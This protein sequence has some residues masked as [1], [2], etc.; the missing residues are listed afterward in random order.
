VIEAKV[1]ISDRAV[2]YPGAYIARGSSIGERTII[3]SNV[4]IR[5]DTLIG[6]DVIIHSNSVIGSDGFGYTKDG[7]EYVKIPQ[8]G[9]VEIEDSCE[10][11]ASVTIDRA[12]IGKTIIGKGTKIDNLVQI[13]H[14]VEIGE[15][16]IIVS[17]AGVA[18]STKIGSGV[19]IGGQA[20][21]VGHIKL[22][23]GAMIGAKAGVLGDVGPGKTVSGHPAIDHNIWLRVVSLVKKLPEIKGELKRLNER[24][25]NLEKDKKESD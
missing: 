16:S 1:K 10:I 18:G 23:D 11:G 4:S 25:A 9:S 19:Q 17:Q 20:G 14:N 22:G 3:H 21:I 15:N 13:A 2:I 12:T 6:A 5:E 7:D 24:L 8:K